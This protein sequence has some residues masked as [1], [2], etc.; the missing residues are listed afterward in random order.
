MK[1]LIRNPAVNWRVESHREIHVREILEDP[2]RE[3]E[4]GAAQ[5]VGTV[6]LLDGG[7][8]HQLNF[9]GG[10]IWKLCDGTM[11]RDAV[12]ARLLELFEVEQA[13]LREDVDAF[14]EEM[15]DKGLINEQR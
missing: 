10:E 9:L 14:V 8:M 1:K 3:G 5:L 15:I 11:D 4:D 2:G 7:I 13:I 6:T 12:T